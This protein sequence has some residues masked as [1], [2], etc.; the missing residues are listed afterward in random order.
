[1]LCTSLLVSQAVERFKTAGR[2]K[3]GTDNNNHCSLAC[4]SIL[5]SS[6]CYIPLYI[7]VVFTQWVVAFNELVSFNL[8]WCICDLFPSWSTR[9]HL[10]GILF[11]K[12]LTINDALVTSFINSLWWCRSATRRLWSWAPN[13]SPSTSRS[14]IWKFAEAR[15]GKTLFPSS[16]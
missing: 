13:T 9:D 2:N 8:M 11:L 3:P 6:S 12:I 16:I 14:W 7:P 4:N 5:S 1:M 10:Q 15:W